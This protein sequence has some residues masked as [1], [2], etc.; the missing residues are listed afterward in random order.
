M[1][2]VLKI[3]LL[4][5]VLLSTMFF[6]FVPQYID[7]SKNKS[8]INGPF[9][10]ISWYD[11]IPFIAD[12][13]CDALLWNRDLVKEHTYGHV[14]LPR[15]QKANMAYKKQDYSEAARLLQKIATD[16]GDDVLADD[17]IFNLAQINETFFSNKDEA[18]RL[19]E[20]ILTKYPGS[21]FVNQA[22]KNYRRLR[23]DKADVDVQ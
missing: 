9:E 5:L 3:I 6:L 17:A 21:S 20:E 7:R 14:D 4:V 10:K 12:L 2:K 13:H 16:F 15:M 22:R 23:G 1:K 19:Y 11:S 18:K 8:T